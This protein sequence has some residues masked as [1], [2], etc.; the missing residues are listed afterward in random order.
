V[1]E[2]TQQRF[3]AKVISV[4]ETRRNSMRAKII[5]VSHEATLTGAPILLLNILLHLK[6]KLPYD[7]VIVLGRDGPVRARFEEIGQVIVYPELMAT[8]RKARLLQRLRLLD[9]HNAKQV[10]Q[11]FAFEEVKIIFS[12]TIANGDL[13][14]ILNFSKAP[15]ITY[16]HELAYAIQ[17]QDPAAVA[18]VQQHTQ[19]FLAGS[20]AVRQQLLTIGVAPEKIDIVPSS[21][22]YD[23]LVS[24]LAGIAVPQ[25]RAELQMEAHQQVV[26]AVGTVEWRKGSDLFVQ[27]ASLLVREQP[28]VHF[29]WVGGVSNSPEHWRMQYDIDH[30][31][32]ASRVHLIPVTPDYLKYIAL[33]DV[34]VLPSREDPFPL[35]VLEASVAGK[36]T[37]CFADTGGSPEFVGTENGTVVPYGNVA[38]MAESITA[39]LLDASV[40]AAK[41][42]HACRLVQQK[43]NIPVAAGRILQIIQ[44]L[45]A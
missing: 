29:V 8:G 20:G 39:L 32:L 18:K 16:V 13:V 44:Q 43:Y 1:H 19:R 22:P 38:A 24:R 3:I 31:G 5:F 27:M 36:P 7:F 40:R 12:N 15:V 25:V 30:L 2:Q 35:V 17:A 42:E 34:F 37:V 28:Q 10:Q 21:V 14:E 41:G 26:V 45:T 9:K 4:D 11:A 6:D 23:A 33:A